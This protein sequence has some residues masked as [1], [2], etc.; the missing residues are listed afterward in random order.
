M[1]GN[2][3]EILS[4]LRRVQWGVH[5]PAGVNTLIMQLVTSFSLVLSSSLGDFHGG[6]D[7]HHWTVIIIVA[8]HDHR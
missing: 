4:R 1:W 8:F 5:I 3:C 7:Y 6:W 2:Q